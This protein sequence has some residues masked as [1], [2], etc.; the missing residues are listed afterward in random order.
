MLRGL[1]LV[2]V[3]VVCLLI[4]G[5]AI[6]WSMGLASRLGIMDRPGGHKLH[7][8]STPFVGGVGILSV[9]FS[10]FFLLHMLLPGF[11]LSPLQGILVGVLLLFLTG[12]A[13]DI[14]HLSFKLRFVIQ[15][16]AAL[17]MVFIGGVELLSFG[18]LLPGLRFDLG[19][20]S[21]PL[22]IFATVG[23]INAVNMI[24]GIDGMSGSLSVVSLALAG[25]V[26]YAADQAAYVFLIVGLIGGLAGFLYFNLRYPGNKRARVFLGDNG[27]MVLGFVFAWLLI[28][29]SQGKSPAMTPVTALW[30]FALPLMDTVGVMLR[31][32]WLRKSPFRPDR[33][34]LHHLFVRAGYRV[35]DIVALA[36]V[37]Q[38]G[39]GLVGVAGLVLRVP[40]VL[41]FGLFL[42]V[43]AAYF[44][45]IARPWRLVPGLRRIR[46]LLGLPCSQ[47]RGIFV[48]Y[49]SRE[50]SPRLLDAI[51]GRLGQGY[52]YDLSVYRRDAP[53]KDGH[54]MYCVLQLSSDGDESL[55]G[56]IS[57][58]ALS[59]MKHLDCR[60]GVEVRLFVCRDGAN[61]VRNRFSVAG[62]SACNREQDRRGGCSTLIYSA[63][64]GDGRLR[65]G[66]ALDF[67]AH[68]LAGK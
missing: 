9:F 8:A 59:I 36:A 44:L 14:L 38:I 12:F 63:V 64:Q 39:L 43:F 13:D 25:L 57:R 5:V 51:S 17:S 46:H 3:F 6:R 56:R 28:A 1:E 31:R 54:D 2:V 16:A 24:D 26:A 32:L 61:E 30:L 22:T 33:H 49:S 4:S 20:F 18:E 67:Q 29:L 40:E 23:L 11:F 48:S 15:A 53:T 35:C 34:H 7:D 60:K 47:V 10:V 62:V 52:D 45:L 65:S 37:V 58:D 41:M 55:V 66:D 68:S 50:S 19:L 27:S 21:I 42:G